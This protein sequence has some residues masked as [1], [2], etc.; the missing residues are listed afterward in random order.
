[1]HAQTAAWGR[2]FILVAMT[3]LSHGSDLNLAPTMGPVARQ[4]DAGPRR[5]LE[6]IA[7]EGF[8]A[9]QL[10]GT[11]AGLRAR[12]LSASARRALRATLARHGL[13]LSGLDLFI[14]PHHFRASSYVDRAM[15]AAQEGI[16]LAADLGRIPV[17]LALPVA[18]LEPAHGEALVAAADR[19][20]VPLAVHAEA[21]LEAL[22]SWVQAIDLPA[23][24][25]G[26]DPAALL[27][28]GSDPAQRAAELSDRLIVGRLSDLEP[29]GS[30]GLPARRPAGQGELDVGAYRV[31]LDL[32]SRRHGPVVLDLRQ[33]E[34][35]LEGA[36]AARTA[37]E[38]AS[39]RE[40]GLGART[41]R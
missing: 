20:S 40:G 9:V 36:R 26:L 31:S 19:A 25:V 29:G 38:R 5:A 11:M 1:M 10:D 21:E 18:Q 16:E 39:E 23:L 34:S 37:W 12:E 32:S 3:V 15:E 24:G 4:D 41:G 7:G 2:S 8:P 14:P 28:Q 30:Q 27:A 22:R 33:L 35:P 17:S 6:R 13:R